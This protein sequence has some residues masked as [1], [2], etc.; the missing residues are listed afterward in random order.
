M[1]D[2]DDRLTVNVAMEACDAV[3]LHG[4]DEREERQRMRRRIGPGER[5]KVV[6][7]TDCRFSH[8]SGVPE[9][10]GAGSGR[11]SP[12]CEDFCRSSRERLVV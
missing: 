7:T 1:N 6:G 11:E 4:A 5:G 2:L 9:S 8:D 10:S 12:S 3:I